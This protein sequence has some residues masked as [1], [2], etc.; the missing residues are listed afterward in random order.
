MR[1]DKALI[2]LVFLTS[3]DRLIYTATFHKIDGLWRLRGVR[4][5]L[6]QFMMRI[7]EPAG[8][9]FDLPTPPELLAIPPLPPLTL[10]LIVPPIPG[11]RSMPEG[12]PQPKKK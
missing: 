10:D 11:P 7:V 1:G 9:P 8:P 2:D 12:P 5:T 6:Q 3:E 4:E